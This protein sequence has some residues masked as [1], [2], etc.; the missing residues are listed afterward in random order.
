M[1]AADQSGEHEVMLGLAMLF[2]MA[3]IQDFLALF[4]HLSGYEWF[5]H[6]VVHRATVFKLAGVEALPQ[7]LVKRGHRDLVSAFPKPK[8]LLVCL[9]GQAFKR[10]LPRC[11]P[12]EQVGDHGTKDWVR[13]DDPLSIRRN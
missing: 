12:R 11:K 8:S 2:L 4:P 6:S 10:V 7:D 3:P 9:L 13:N 5:M 1:S